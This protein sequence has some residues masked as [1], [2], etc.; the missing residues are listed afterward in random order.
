MLAIVNGCTVPVRFIISI[1]TGEE[2]R[3][4]V[5]RLLLVMVIEVTLMPNAMIQSAGAS[6][7]LT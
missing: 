3:F 2:S 5:P 6:P 1:G 4:T 7:M